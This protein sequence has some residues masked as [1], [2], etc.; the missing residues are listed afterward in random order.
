MPREDGETALPLPYSCRNDTR[1]TNSPQLGK[2]ED[3][4]VL[5]HGVGLRR[6]SLNQTPSL[7]D[8]TLTCLFVKRAEKEDQD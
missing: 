3:L 8:V 6:K 4:K 7:P 5:Q 2:P 1:H